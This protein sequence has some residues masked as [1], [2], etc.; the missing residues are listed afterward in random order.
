MKSFLWLFASALLAFLAAFAFNFFFLDLAGRSRIDQLLLMGISTAAL[1]YLIY[2]VRQYS[3]PIGNI[4]L[5]ELNRKT[6]AAS[7]RE[8]L[9]GILLALLFLAVYFYFGLQINFSDSDTTDN[10]LDADNYPWMYRIAA[11]EGHALEM[12]GPHPYAFFI[13]RPFGALL[14][15]FTSDF[16]IS[17][18]LLNALAGASCVF[19]GW[20]FIRRRSKNSAYALLIAALLG[21][22]T[23]HFFFGSVIESYIF[24][25]AAL[26]G[27]ILA[28]DSG[29]GTLFAPIAMGVIT[30]GI[31]LTNFVQNFIG[32]VINEF[33]AINKQNLK[34][35]I[36]K[37]LRFAALVLSLGIIISI[38]HAAW[39]PSA[40]LFF[41]LSDARIEQDF[42]KSLLQEPQWKIT[43]R[44]VLLVRTI[45]LYTVIAPEP[46]VFGKEVGATLPYFNFFK[47]TPQIYAFS[48]YQSAGN[49]LVFTWA[50]LM[51]ISGI[52]FFK[53]IIQ[54]RKV[55]ISLAFLLS[56]V[57]NFL[58]HFTYGFEPFLYSPDWA[59]AL[60]FFVGLALIPL[61]NNRWFQAILLVFI[62]ML[63]WNQVHF[64]QFI[65]EKIAP[66]YQMGG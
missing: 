26:I 6:V 64:F 20:V 61:A 25:A 12:R 43:G 21:L 56:L 37:I 29:R 24:S 45:L 3:I 63:A 44:I 2:E 58:L 42:S 60:I 11:P 19:M 5:Q 18:I 28:I 47:L 65:L 22:S 59:Y 34:P 40:R 15:I 7:L 38:I 48:S 1:T 49:I 53:Q 17:A 31:T 8:H 51:L 62:L 66:F 52:F 14:N 33:S 39:Y 57:F 16:R 55:D 36:L 41:Q 9:P 10:F 32:Y 50:G 30:F 23:S 27:F 35:V 4:R 13:L 54:T 46:F